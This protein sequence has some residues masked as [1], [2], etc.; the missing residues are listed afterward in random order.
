MDKRQFTKYSTVVLYYKSAPVDKIIS[1]AT[2]YNL[3]ERIRECF[4]FV[5]LLFF[6]DD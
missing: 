1:V 5:P 6:A 3:F 4:Q 2:L